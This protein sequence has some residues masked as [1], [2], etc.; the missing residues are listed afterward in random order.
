MPWVW[1]ALPGPT[2]RGFQRSPFLDPEEPMYLGF[3]VMISGA[4]LFWRPKTGPNLESNPEL[5]MC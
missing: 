3:L 4:V 5:P 2:I 1:S